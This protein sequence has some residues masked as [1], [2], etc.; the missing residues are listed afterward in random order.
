MRLYRPVWKHGG[1]EVTCAKWYVQM[2]VNRKLIRRSLGTTDKRV[3]EERARALQQREERRAAGLFD[4]TDDDQQRPLSEHVADFEAMLRSRGCTEEH[5]KD[6]MF[7]L[8]EVIDATKATLLRDLDAPR[9]ARHLSAMK[10]QNASARTINRRLQAARQF[11]RWL[12]ATRRFPYDPLGSL[13]PL[14][15]AADRRHVRRALKPEEL[16]RLVAAAEAR[17]LADAREARVNAG[18][19]AP[20]ATRLR[21]LGRARALLYTFAAGTGLRLGELQR[22]RW[23]DLD[24]Q[25]GLVL[26]PAKSAKSR[27]DQ[28]V[29]LRSDLVARLKAYRPKGAVPADLVFTASVFPTLRTFKRD[30]AAA[31]LIRMEK[32]ID[33]NRKWRRHRDKF[34]PEGEDGR[35]LDFHCLRVTF[36]SALVANGEHPRVAQALARHAKIETTMAAYTDLSLLDLRGAVEKTA[37]AVAPPTRAAATSA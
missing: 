6:R 23:G 29:P 24:L 28:S 3:A 1:A 8:A 2:Y 20:E 37:R 21:A 5:L 26:V 34:F 30:L 11:T 14:N 16:A 12:V 10:E 35:C 33:A 17:P 4:P 25:R 31:G 9:V 7:C 18:V 13:K 36:V 32:A 15:E 22:L 19:S 27:R